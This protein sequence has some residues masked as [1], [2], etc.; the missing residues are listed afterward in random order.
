MRPG[1]DFFP[2]YSEFINEILNTEVLAGRIMSNYSR[3]LKL[4][5]TLR[6]ASAD[7]DWEGLVGEIPAEADWRSLQ[8]EAKRLGYD[9]SVSSS[10]PDDEGNRRRWLWVYAP[11]DQD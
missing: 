10:D 4:L 7:D 6:P 3:A 1:I 2:D 11:E 8:D 5:P 9:A